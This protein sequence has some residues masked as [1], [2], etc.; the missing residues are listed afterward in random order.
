[1]SLTWTFMCCVISF[2]LGYRIKAQ[3]EINQQSEIDSLKVHVQLLKKEQ[4]ELLAKADYRNFLADQKYF[5][6]ESQFNN[7][8]EQAKK[9]AFFKIIKEDE[10]NLKPGLDFLNRL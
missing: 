8:K 1:M 3:F 7:F 10:K 6:L 9:E 2:L 5:S 4:E